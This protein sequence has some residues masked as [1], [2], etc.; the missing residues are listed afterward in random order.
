M[1][2]RTIVIHRAIWYRAI[3]NDVTQDNVVA[4]KTYYDEHVNEINGLSFPGDDGIWY[5]FPRKVLD[6]C[7]LCV[8]VVEDENDE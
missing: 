4:L 1:K 8:E 3:F 6:E 7:V 5:C 2:A